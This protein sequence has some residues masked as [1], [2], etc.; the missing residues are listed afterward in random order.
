[1]LFFGLFVIEESFFR[2]EKVLFLNNGLRGLAGMIQ[3]TLIGG[4]ITLII[5]S[6]SATVG[7]T[8]VLGKQKLILFG[9]LA[10]ML[11]SELGTCSDTLLATIKG[12]RQAIKAGLFHLLFN[13]TT[14]IIGLLSF[15]YFH[16]L[17]VFLSQTKP[18]K[19][20]SQMPIC[21]LTL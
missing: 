17:V 13:F 9:S 1:M 15:E 10:I 14:L 6:S 12:S 2:L 3:G 4:L 21:C 8:I 11:G 5:Q 18:W 20:K 16:R 7:M 19:T